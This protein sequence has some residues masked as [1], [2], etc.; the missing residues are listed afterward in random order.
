MRTNKRECERT[1]QQKENES[2]HKY[3]TMEKGKYTKTNSTED[4]AWKQNKTKVKQ[5]NE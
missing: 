3:N 5:L 4:S 2:K 1:K